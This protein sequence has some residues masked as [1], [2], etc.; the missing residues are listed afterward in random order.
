MNYYTFENEANDRNALLL[1]KKKILPK[2][3][4]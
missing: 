2:L 1:F 3:Q 4:I